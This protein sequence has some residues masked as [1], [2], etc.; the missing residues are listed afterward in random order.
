MLQDQPKLELH[1][2][3]RSHPS[4]QGSYLSACV[5]YGRMF[6]ADV[7]KLPDKLALTTADGNERVLVK[8]KPEVGKR[9][10]A[11]AAKRKCPS[12][13]AGRE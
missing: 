10:R 11:A 6:A 1:T 4:P 9:L 8:L 2:V 5:L 3:D 7:S 12:P 13:C